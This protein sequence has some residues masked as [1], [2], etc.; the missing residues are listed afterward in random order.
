MFDTYVHDLYTGGDSHP[1][2]IEMEGGS[3]I[4]VG[5][6]TLFAGTGGNS[7]IST[8]PTKMSNVSISSNLIA[9]G[10]YT[11]FCPRDSSTNVRVLDNR[12]SRLFYPAG[13]EYGPWTDCEKVAQASGNTWDDTG[14]ALGF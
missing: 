14:Q 13:G 8:D 2:D 10:A 12:V 5:H 11:L 3:D 7:A 4:T 6:S 1:D 9:G